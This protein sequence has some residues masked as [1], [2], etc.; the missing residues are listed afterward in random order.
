M[1]EGICVTAANVESLEPRRLLSALGSNPA[2]VDLLALYTPAAAAAHGGEASTRAL[3]QSVV[4]STNAALQ[5]SLIPVTIRLVHG[6]QIAYAGS[7][8]LFTD[9]IRLQ[10]PGDGFLDSAHALR[11]TWGADLVHMVS[12]GAPGGG[13][14]AALLDDLNRPD[15]DT[16]AFSVMDHTSLQP[17]NLTF[18]HEVGHNLGGGHERGNVID[19]AV[20]PFPY[21]YGYRFT[22][23]ASGI[24]Y[25]D[26]M[27]YDPGLV[28]PYFANPL[29]SFDGAPTGSPEGQPDAAD[30]AKTF[31]QTGPFVAAYRATVVTDTA[32][33]AAHVYELNPNGQTL[34]FT[35]RYRDDSVVDLSSIDTQDVFVTTPEGFNL[36]AELLGVSGGSSDNEFQ[37]L[38]RYRVTLPASSPPIDSLQISLRPNQVKDIHGNFAVGGTLAFP[39]AGDGAD[40][41]L[42]AARD[43]GTPSP[44]SIVSDSLDHDDTD[45]IYKITIASR[46]TLSARLTGLSDDAN[47]FV[48]R[49]ANNNGVYDNPGDFIAGSFNPGSGDRALGVTLDPGTYYLWVYRQQPTVVTSYRLA[50][51]LYTDTM[52]PTATLDATDLKTSG[53]PHVDFAVDYADDHEVHGDTARFWSA[54]DVNVQLDG[55]GGFSFFY[56]PDPALNPQFPQ[57]AQTFRTIYRILAFNSTTGFTAADNGLYTISIH[58]NAPPDPRVRDVAGNDIPLIT[59]GSFRIAIGPPDAAAPTA[60]LTA[61]P[62]LVPGGSSHE[63]TVEYRDN[64]APDGATIGNGDVHVTGPGGFDQLATLVSVSPAPSVGSKRIATYRITAPGGAWDHTDNG[65]YSVAI[66]AGEVRDTSGNALPAGSIGAI[67]VHVPLPGD[68][69]GDDRVNLA[70]FNV[71][72]TNFGRFGRGVQHG[73][74]TYDGVVNLQDFNVLASRFGQMLGPATSSGS[75]DDDEV[76]VR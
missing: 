39:T 3:I 58:P 38:A 76:L 51:L 44:T 62:I 1:R 61:P 47:V 42:Q 17:S 35:V 30:L 71:L 4:D 70:D 21:S 24:T 20:G 48:L 27:S 55:G 25:H 18:A 60:Q 5:R 65:S 7:G 52:P 34:T 33:P 22:S 10:T 36:S 59:L 43:L 64:V 72:A 50:V 26:I 29:V 53:A 11:D 28:I 68:A 74:F 67:D 12:D 69:N 32:A 54:V 73:D 19:P 23:P 56:F 16:L 75:T 40:W 9:R 15:L 6:E 63:F 46:S 8:N 14:N 41:N 45:D 2:V 31:I 66:R 37:K 13:G 57:N 49:D